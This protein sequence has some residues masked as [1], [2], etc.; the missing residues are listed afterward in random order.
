MV[1]EGASASDIE[2]T[3]AEDQRIVT[4]LREDNSYETYPPELLTVA[5][6]TDTE[7]S[8]IRPVVAES[9]WRA[10]AISLFAPR[11]ITVGEYMTTIDAFLD[12]VSS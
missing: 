2:R 1:R 5:L 11:Q 9:W 8:M 12:A 6:L 10:L 7:R 4:L 3:I